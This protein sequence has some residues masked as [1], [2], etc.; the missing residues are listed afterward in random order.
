MAEKKE[1]QYVSDNARLMAEWNY[2]KNCGL[3]PKGVSSNSNKKI[4]WKCNHGHEW[5]ATI[6]NRNYG[7]GCPICSNKRIL[8]GY[9]DL[10]AMN[11]TVA[12][13]WNHEKNG[14]LK[15][16]SVAPN[17]GRT[18]WWRCE[19]GHEWQARIAER[20]KG[21][22]CPQCARERRRPAK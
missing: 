15:P 18:V 12:S 14:T 8:I 21:H 6:A 4:W 7:T 11:P 19:Q 2:E 16:E 5:Q 10:K 22:G 3:M 17:S 13:E 1:K 9:N 20:N